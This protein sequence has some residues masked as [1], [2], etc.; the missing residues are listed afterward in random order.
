MNN[1]FIRCKT[2]LGLFFGA[3]LLFVPILS[4]PRLNSYS[5]KPSVRIAKPGKSYS[6]PK[7]YVKKAPCAG[8]RKPS[9]ANGLLK[10]KIVPAHTK[11]T[12]KGYKLVNPYARSK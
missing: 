8:L 4:K 3:I 12:S 9:K 5:I 11:R 10:S 7:P 1:A 6:T 2:G